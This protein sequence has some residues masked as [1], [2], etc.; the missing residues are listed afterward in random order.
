MSINTRDDAARQELYLTAIGS[1]IESGD[2]GV[3]GRGNRANGLI[4]ML[5]PMSVEGVSGKNPVYHVGKL[6]NLAATG[7][8]ARCT[9][10]PAAPAP[11]AWCPRPAGTSTT[12]GRSWSGS[13]TPD[14]VDT[15]V[16]DGSSKKSWATSTTCAPLLLDGRLATA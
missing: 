9:R 4:S 3:V 2:E 14:P 8:P 16:A 6:Y 13:P 15:A 5:R 1:S 12:P 10:S 7:P 11:S